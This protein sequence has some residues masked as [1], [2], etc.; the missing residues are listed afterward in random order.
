MWDAPP[1][2]YYGIERVDLCGRAVEQPTKFG[3][4]SKMK[5]R[6]RLGSRFR[7]RGHNCATRAVPFR[8]TRAC[9]AASRSSRNR[10]SYSPTS[11][12]NSDTAPSQ[13]PC[14]RLLVRVAHLAEFLERRSLIVGGNPDAR[15]RYRDFRETVVQRGAYVDAPTFRR[16]LHGVRQEIQ[17]HLLHCSL[18]RA[19]LAEPLVDDT[20]NRDPT[21]ARA[22]AHQ[23]QRV[24][25]RLRQIEFRHVERAS[26][27]RGRRALPSRAVFQFFT[28]HITTAG[29]S[30]GLTSL[31]D[32]DRIS[33]RWLRS[34]LTS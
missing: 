21:P 17:Q 20:I 22:F 8:T 28:R 10:A 2:I 5:R 33:G 11:T 15:I 32:F 9:P 4:V 31:I 34:L 30:R 7:R 6:K 26:A 25:D 1:A 3:L 14:L 13:V 29:S 27:W 12:C 23:R 24:V 16:E 19:D 18:V